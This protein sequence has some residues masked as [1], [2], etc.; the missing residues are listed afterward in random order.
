MANWASNGGGSSGGGSSSSWVTKTANYTASAGDNILADT[1]GGAFMI[2]LPASPAANDAVRVLDLKNS[3]NKNPLTISPNGG[4]IAGVTLSPVVNVSGADLV[5]VYV[6]STTGWAVSAEKVPQLFSKWVINASDSASTPIVEPDGLTIHSPD[7]A[8]PWKT[9]KA[10]LS[11]SSG[12]VYFEFQHI[13]V[14]SNSFFVGIADST[15]SASSFIGSDSHS[16]SID[17]GGTMR[18]TGTSGGTAAG[19]SAG[20]TVGVA[21]DFSGR[22][23]FYKNNAA[24]GNYTGATIPAVFPALTYGAVAAIGKLKTAAS[25]CTYSPPA[26]YS[27][28]DS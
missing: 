3:F 1:S 16:W 27:Y 28:W 19:F 9:F 8:A 21:V 25:Q 7:G 11:R 20:D 17:A 5:F 22:I 13:A 14:S 15:S 10:N 18:G 6:D 26:G 2:T 12:K 24:N 23:D 4:K